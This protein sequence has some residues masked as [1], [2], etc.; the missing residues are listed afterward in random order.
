MGIETAIIVGLAA[1]SAAAA[2]QQGRKEA[3]AVTRQAAAETL[4]QAK[5]TQLQTSKAK[6]SF[7]NSGLT[8]E[9]TPQL[10]LEGILNAGMEDI[11]MIAANAN[12]RSKNIMAKARTDAI[13][14]LAKTGVGAAMGGFSG[15]ASAGMTTAATPSLSPTGNAQMGAMFTD[16]GLTGV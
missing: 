14:G 15:G 9:G 6:V 12:T 1:A 2:I 10:S 7:I 3:K 4:Q 11:N 13:L 8:L 5:K 16:A